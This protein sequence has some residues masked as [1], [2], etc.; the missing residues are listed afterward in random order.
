MTRDITD[1]LVRLAIVRDHRT[2]RREP[3]LTRLRRRWP[4]LVC[5]VTSC[6]PIRCQE[7]HPTGDRC[8]RCRRCGRSWTSL[9]LPHIDL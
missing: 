2:R 6:V 8:V 1:P 3:R 5:A 9:H 4:R 7:F